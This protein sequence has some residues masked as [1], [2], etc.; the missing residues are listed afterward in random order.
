MHEIDLILKERRNRESRA[1][2][3]WETFYQKTERADKLLEEIEKKIK[4]R[5][6]IQEARKQF[7]TSYITSFEVYFKDTLLTLLKMVGND[8]FI[9]EVKRKFDMIDLERIIKEKLSIN[10]LIVSCFNFQDL[11]QVN[12]AFSIILSVS[13]F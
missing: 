10:E 7:V 12:K 3:P 2:W 1:T 8:K 6:S 11:D 9:E 13:F 4:S 5:N